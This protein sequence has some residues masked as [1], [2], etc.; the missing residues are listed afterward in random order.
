MDKKIFLQGLLLGY[1]ISA[2]AFFVGFEQTLYNKSTNKTDIDNGTITTET[3]SNVSSFK[4]GSRNGDENSNRVEFVYNANEKTTNPIVGKDKKLLSFGINY[5]I[6]LER[7]KPVE[8]IVPYVR[9]GASYSISD[10]KY[11]NIYDGKE[12]NYSAAGLLGG[13]GTY[14]NINKNLDLSLGFDVGYRQWQDLYYGNK[15]MSS[16]ENFSKFYIG[17]S[18]NFSSK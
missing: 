11:R 4:I 12:Y 2:N 18:Y 6:T 10:Q 15:K 13:I 8:S 14:Y 7:M 9:L 1:A 5:N 17:T 3:T 16:T